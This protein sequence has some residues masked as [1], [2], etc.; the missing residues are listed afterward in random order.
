MRRPAGRR[1]LCQSQRH[2]R[3][4]QLRRSYFGGLSSLDSQPL[5]ISMGNRGGPTLSAITSE[6]GFGSVLTNS[7]SLAWNKTSEG[8]LVTHRMPSP[9]SASG[10]AWRPQPWSPLGPFLALW[11]RGQVF[12]R[13]KRRRAEAAF[14]VRGIDGVRKWGW[15]L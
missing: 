10:V 11:E 8:T 5:H 7:N 2:Q 3:G 9:G 12:E 13:M 14:V 6:P 1:G 15:G 4:G